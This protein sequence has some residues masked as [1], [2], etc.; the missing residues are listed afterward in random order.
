VEGEAVTDGIKITFLVAAVLGLALGGYWGHSEA[1]D[2]NASLES[3][4]YFAPTKVASDFAR[5]QFTHSDP[6][7]ARQAVMFQIHLLEQLQKVDRA[8]RAYEVGELGW[9]YTRLAMIEEAAGHPEAETSALANARTILK[10]ARPGKEELTDDKLKDGVKR[11][12]QIAERLQTPYKG[13]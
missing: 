3:I 2:T 9:A 5:L 6:D 1:V 10:Q 13:R 7:H 11:M 8:F 4:Q 12:D